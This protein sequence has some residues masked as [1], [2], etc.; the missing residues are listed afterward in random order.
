MSLQACQHNVTKY[1]TTVV[2]ASSSGNSSSSSSSSSSCSSYFPQIQIWFWI[3]EVH[4]EVL[5]KLTS[6]LKS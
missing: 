3:Y 2:A 6:S 1:T 4:F 5:V